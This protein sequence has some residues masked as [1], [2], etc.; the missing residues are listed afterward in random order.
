MSE[1]KGLAL[2]TGGA[3]KSCP[4]PLHFTSAPSSSSGEPVTPTSKLGRRSF[5]DMLV[6]LLRDQRGA[7][8]ASPH[9]VSGQEEWRGGIWL[10]SGGQ[11]GSG[12]F[13]IRVLA[14]LCMCTALTY[15]LLPRARQSPRSWAAPRLQTTL[16]W[17][18]QKRL[19]QGGG[20]RLRAS[21]SI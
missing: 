11:A 14:G 3:G 20:T 21:S 18:G 12:E 2:A 5:W 1:T 10:G 16:C 8:P 19:A 6:M 7:G 4:P 15:P 17:R 9:G 13:V